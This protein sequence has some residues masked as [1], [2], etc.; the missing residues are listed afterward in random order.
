MQITSIEKSNV[1]IIK[2]DDPMGFP[3]LLNNSNR[4]QVIQFK[5]SKYTSFK[6]R[7]N[8]KKET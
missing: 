5:C 3:V 2:N 6:N 7:L 8:E 4:L 1:L